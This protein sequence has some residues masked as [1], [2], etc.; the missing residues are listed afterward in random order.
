MLLRE[1]GAAAE[2][3][4]MRAGL[5]DS[6]NNILQTATHNGLN[7]STGLLGLWTDQSCDASLKAVG[8][9]IVMKMRG[10]ISF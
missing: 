6:T 7:M 8:N 10:I 4:G 5:A 9:V 2:L 3:H 1:A